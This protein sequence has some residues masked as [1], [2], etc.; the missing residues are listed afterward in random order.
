MSTRYACVACGQASRFI[1]KKQV[2]PIASMKS[3]IG[4]ASAF[5]LSAPSGKL[6]F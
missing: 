2:R 3:I 5:L 4:G 6:L 1:P